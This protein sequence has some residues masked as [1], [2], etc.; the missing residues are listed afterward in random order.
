MP[1]PAARGPLRRLIKPLIRPL[2][3]PDVFDFWASKLNR[4]WSWQRPLA[5]VVERHVEAQDAVTLVLK[6]NRHFAGFVPGQHVNLSAEIN[7]AR[8]TRSYSLTDVPRSDRRVA[9]TV[10]RIEGGRMSEHLCTRVQVGDV[11]ELG[12]AFGEMT[13]PAVVDGRWLLLAAGS[14]I[15]PLMSLVRAWRAKPEAAELTLV[16]WARHRAELCYL[17]E[18]RELAQANPKFHLQIVVTR[19]VLRMSDELGERISADFLQRL[20]HALDQQQVYACGPSGFVAEARRIL[21]TRAAR[22]HAEAFTPPALIA[23]VAGTVRVEL[24]ASGRTLELASGQALLPALEAQG[25][26]PAYG[27]RMG[28]CNT[29]ACGKLEGTTQDLNSGEHSAE[30]SSALRLCINRAVSDLVLD[31]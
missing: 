3:A 12:P 25:V 5:R 6:P 14:G 8:V 31:L 17:R 16:Y 21:G 10:K 30:R 29:C 26:K 22:F 9:L 24:R 19:E 13:W 20:V 27:C 15:T 2:I 18:L 4:A 23:D 7:G 28:I 11:L 1:T